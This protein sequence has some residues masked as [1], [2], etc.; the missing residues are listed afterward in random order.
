M[1]FFPGLCHCLIFRRRKETTNGRPFF[2]IAPG[3][4]PPKDGE[5]AVERKKEKKKER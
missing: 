5:D 3:Q 1:V 4:K 2:S